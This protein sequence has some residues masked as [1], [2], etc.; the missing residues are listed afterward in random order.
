MGQHIWHCCALRI[1]RLGVRCSCCI[2]PLCA[3]P[4]ALAAEEHSALHMSMISKQ[5][6]QVTHWEDA[7]NILKR[8]AMPLV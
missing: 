4:P 2:L 8:I 5:H 7:D 6:L 3:A 1:D